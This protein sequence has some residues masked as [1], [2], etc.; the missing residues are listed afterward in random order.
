MYALPAQLVSLLLALAA[1]TDGWLGVYLDPEAKNA[2]LAEVVPGSPA[3]KAGLQAGDVMLAVGDQAIASA[4]EFVAAIRK[5]SPGDRV[6][7]KIRRQDRESI[8]LVKLG[9]RPEV[10]AATPAAP[11]KVAPGEPAR[12]AGEAVAPAPPTA[13]APKSPEAPVS[14][15]APTAKPADPGQGYL[16]ISVQETATGV[17]IDRVLPGSPAAA[18]GLREGEFV[19]TFGEQQIADFADLDRLLRKARP[20][21]KVA[22]GLRSQDGVR[23]VLVEIGTRDAEG[24]QAR[25]EQ[26]QEPIR[27]LAPR[28][29]ELPVGSAATSS[30]DLE[31]EVKALRAELEQL[32]KQ[33]DELRKRGGRE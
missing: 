14:A 18:A 7:L 8:V 23:S 17:Q 32:R 16:G 30:A 3:A 12:P 25:Q 24:G 22:I 27:P 10:A 33:L 13:T 19:Q 4:D 9:E 15:P 31:K 21:R 26:A 6:R 29:S 28:E 2:V 11:P 1:A 20:G 5:A